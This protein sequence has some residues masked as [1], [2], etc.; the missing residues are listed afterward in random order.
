MIVSSN[1]IIIHLQQITTHTLND[2]VPRI[3][4]TT[5]DVTVNEP[6]GPARVCLEISNRIDGD[7]FPT[8]IQVTLTTGPKAGA[9]NQATGTLNVIASCDSTF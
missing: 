4:I 3:N 6:D 9:T 7:N 2:T 1:I 5:P 8:G